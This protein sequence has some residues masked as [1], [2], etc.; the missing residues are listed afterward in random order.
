VG[1]QYRQT[2]SERP[3]I[4]VRFEK[5]PQYQVNDFDK[6]EFAP[7]I[8]DETVPDN[9]QN[10]SDLPLYWGP[11]DPNYPS[12]LTD[13]SW[14]PQQWWNRLIG[15]WYSTGSGKDQTMHTYHGTKRV[16]ELAKELRSISPQNKLNRQLHLENWTEADEKVACLDKDIMRDLAIQYMDE[17][18]HLVNQSHPRFGRGWDVRVAEYMLFFGVEMGLVPKEQCC[19]AKFMVKTGLLQENDHLEFKRLQTQYSRGLMRIDLTRL[20][21]DK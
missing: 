18:A 1:K 15:R 20:N 6:L 14:R 4:Q 11:R 12:S 13:V 7:S 8:R 3:T 9:S 21:T 19:L 2:I 5:N 16:A 17:Y 10:I